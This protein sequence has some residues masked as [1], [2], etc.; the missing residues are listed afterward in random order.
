MRR[1]SGA[2]YSDSE[3]KYLNVFYTPIPLLLKKKLL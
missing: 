1:R 3:E 2:L